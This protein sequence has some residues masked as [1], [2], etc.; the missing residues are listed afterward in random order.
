MAFGLIP[1]IICYST[2]PYTGSTGSTNT[3]I[4]QIIIDHT[5]IINQGLS[6]FIVFVKLN[7]T[8]LRN[9]N[10]GG[11]V[12]NINGN[13]IKFYDNDF[14]LLTWDIEH[15]N[16]AD[17]NAPSLLCAWVKLPYISLQ[18]DTIFNIMYGDP[19]AQTFVGG[20]PWTE[21]YV[22][23]YHLGNGVDSTT[24]NLN[25]TPH[26]VNTITYTAPTRYGTLFNGQTPVYY[27]YEGQSTAFDIPGGI[28]L[29]CW[30]YIPN[31][32]NNPANVI[33][34][35]W[36]D[37]GYGYA[38]LL[39]SN[40][41]HMIVNDT[42][43]NFEC[44]LNDITQ[45]WGQWINVVGIFIPNQGIYL[46]I[47]GENLASNEIDPVSSQ[48]ISNVPFYIGCGDNNGYPVYRFNGYLSECK[49]VNGVL[50]DNQIYHE[51]TNQI[52]PGN[53]S[54]PGFMIIGDEKNI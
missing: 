3:Y 47:N 51:Y 15:Y 38:L 12:A 53:I 14:N 24:N 33:M 26:N 44:I 11:H 31:D 8:T 48:N 10:D 2:V 29:S 6:D 50:S 36:T 32:V 41:L 30:M 49:V 5:Q 46:W 17:P 42:N 20:N 7:H 25:L 1:G 13:D 4:R 43:V 27:K 23:V 16:G 22:G 37:Q 40:N 28:T 45:F 9:V 35:R 52:N 18:A 54:N 19:T 34:G 39:I 21:Q